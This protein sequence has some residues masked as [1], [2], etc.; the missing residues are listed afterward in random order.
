MSYCPGPGKGGSF[1][2]L[3]GG[4]DIVGKYLFLET[5]LIEKGVYQKFIAIK[6]WLTVEW[7]VL[8]VPGPDGDCRL[9]DL[10]R[11]GPQEPGFSQSW[12]W[13]GTRLPWRRTGRCCC[14]CCW[15]YS[16]LQRKLKQGEDHKKKTIKKG[17]IRLKLTRRRQTAVSMKGVASSFGKESW[18]AHWGE[19]P[20]TAIAVTDLSA[21]TKHKSNC[22]HLELEGEAIKAASRCIHH[23]D[24]GLEWCASDYL[25][26][27]PQAAWTP[28]RLR[29]WSHTCR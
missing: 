23:T 3:R 18:R 16:G 21:Q 6:C 17:V 4:A 7:S 13:T 22:Q 20:R 1:G 26:A 10:V 24:W 11:A 29:H 27:L 14:C 2:M 28:W 15:R 9:L 12:I 5:Q 25:A 8:P 19:P